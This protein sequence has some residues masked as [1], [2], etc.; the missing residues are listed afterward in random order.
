MRKLDI[1]VFAH[2]KKIVQYQ[3]NIEN[4]STAIDWCL[5]AAI[6]SGSA[7]IIYKTFLKYFG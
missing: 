1:N 4:C 6:I 5:Y 3:Q 2:E 7:A